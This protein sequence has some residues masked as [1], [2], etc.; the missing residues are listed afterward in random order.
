MHL[1]VIQQVGAIQSTNNDFHFRCPKRSLEDTH[2]Q[3]Q[4]EKRRRCEVE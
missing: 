4:S 1:K 2:D 3:T